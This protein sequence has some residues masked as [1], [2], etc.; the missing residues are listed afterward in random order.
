MDTSPPAKEWRINAAA[1]IM[2]ADGYVLLGKDHGRN[3]YWHF[4]QGGVIKNESIERTLAREVW[5]EVGL[6]PSDYTIVTRLEGLRYKYPSNHRKI[7]RWIGQEQTY[8]LVRCKTSR[9][10]TD[11]HRSPEFSTTTWIRLQDLKLEMFPKFKR[12]VIRDALKQFFNMDPAVK[13][14]T[15]KNA[16]RPSS[17]ASSTRTPHTMN[18]YL[19]PPGKKL[20]LKD[21]SPDDK[22]L[23][24]GTKEESLI[25]FDKLREELQE[26]QK[27]LFAQHKHKVLVILQAMDAGGKDGCVKHVFSRV[28][29][30]GL[31]VVPFKKPTTE[32]LDHDFLWRVHKEVP[33][34]GQ[35]AIF[36]RSHYED[37]IAVR[38]KKIFPD[39]VWK[40]RYKHVLDF[41]SMLAEEGTIIIKLFLNIS[42]AEQKRRLESRLQDPDK[43][44][45]FCMDDLDDR[46]R[47]EEFQTAYQDLIEKT[48]TPEAPWYIIPG[49]RKWYR[50]LVV[51]RLMVE[52]L[53]QLQLTF[54][55]ANFD[56]SSISIPD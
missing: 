11:L 13:P 38:V 39:P 52:K 21:H 16:S 37:I 27:K 33:A 22:S 26:L 35:I 18:R 56:P 49:D 2:D 46:N 30:Q 6:R 50:N 48:S 19:V 44:W 23:F 1:V 43:L 12:K 41:E 25:E 34:K 14:P 47:W 15:G 20:R 4:P 3:P 36:N 40:R 42:K 55:T 24:A 29:P 9:P 7:T 32:E 10:K 53:R 31:H 51:A 8:F 28:D 17:S 45:K 5:E 54:P